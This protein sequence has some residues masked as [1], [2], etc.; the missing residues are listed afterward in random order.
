[1]HATVELLQ[2][3]N[4][5]CPRY[6]SYP[7]AVEFHDGVQEKLYINQLTQANE[8]SQS[9]WSIYMHFPFCQERC[10]FCACHMIKTSH[11]RVTDQYLDSLMKEMELVAQHIPNRRDVIQFHWGGGT[12]TYYS[13]EA[14]KMVMEAFKKHFSFREDA[15]LAI[16]VDP[17]VTTEHH[18]DAL[19]DMGFNR[20]SMGVQDFD[21]KV[22]KAIGRFQSPQQVENLVQYA[23]NK[24]LYSINFDLVYGLPFQTP[25][26]FEN[27]MDKT[28]A[29]SPDRLAVYSFAYV[30]WMKGHQ[31]KLDVSQLP[32][33]E[34]KFTLLTIARER[35][36]QAGYIDIGMDH[37][38]KPEDPLAIAYQAGTM[39]RNF[40]GYTDTDCLDVLGFGIS[41]IGNVQNGFFQNIKKLKTYCQHIEAG[42][43]PVQRGLILGEDDQ[44]RQKVIQK[45]MCQFAVK[46]TEVNELFSID[47]DQY[48]ST[49]LSEL[50]ELEKEG[51]LQLEEDCIR[52]LPLGK[53]F[54]RNIAVVFDRYFRQKQPSNTFSK[55]I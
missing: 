49:E 55:A 13:P 42:K 44:I 3:Y 19:L 4:K 39:S 8:D 22:Q 6:T 28:L 5:P 34:A 46:K 50:T 43:L 32:K 1:M 47:F 14:L 37:F 17:R 15:E 25:K 24:G 30:P 12:P 11:Q 18:V 31:K 53:S 35:L 7:T 26:S 29:L 21:T 2:R 41:S 40:M 45:L 27:T 20:L 36:L 9:P 54:V 48:F 10:L 33:A 38:A 52:V 23:R 51:F 16:E